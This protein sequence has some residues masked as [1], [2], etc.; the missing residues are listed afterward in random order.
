[1]KDEN[2]MCHMD[3][4]YLP[5]SVKIGDVIGKVFFENNDGHKSW[6]EVIYFGNNQ[7]R[8]RPIKDTTTIQ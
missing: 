4:E 1:M 6:A 2:I 8:F 3:V 7:L 5:S